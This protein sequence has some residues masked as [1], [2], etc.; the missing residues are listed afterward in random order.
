LVALA[1]KK[2]EVLGVKLYKAGSKG[3]YL[4]SKDN[5]GKVEY[6][7]ATGGMTSGSYILKGVEVT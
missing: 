1:K 2:A 4:H 3:V 5:P 7:D 6:E